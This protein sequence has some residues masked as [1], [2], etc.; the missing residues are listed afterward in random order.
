MSPF[1]AGAIAMHDLNDSS[2]AS[3]PSPALSSPCPNTQTNTLTSQIAP[4]TTPPAPCQPHLT[5]LALRLYY[6]GVPYRFAM[7]Q[8]SAVESLHS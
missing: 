8:V 4:R 2:Q 5:E 6:R 1:F 3:S 7:G